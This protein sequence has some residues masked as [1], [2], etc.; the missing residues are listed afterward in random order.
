LGTTGEGVLSADTEYMWVT[1]RFNSSAFTESLH[2]NY[3][4]KIAGPSSG[5]TDTSQDITLRFGSEFPF[6]SDEESLTGFSA[7]ELIV[8]AQK[9]T[10]STRPDPT[11]WR[12]IN[13][14]S[15]ISASTVNGFV[16]PS[17]LTGNTIQITKNLYDGSSSS[18]YDLSDYID[19]PTLNQTGTTY[20]FGDDYLFN[21]NI[22][23]DIQASIYVMNY[24]CNLGQTQFLDSS[25]PTW[26][27]NA[28]YITEIGLYDSN[29]NLMIISKV[30]SPQKR[31]GVQQYP[32]KLDF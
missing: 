4:S 12:E 7:N 27:G 17:T 11:L 22:I 18:L 14:E 23:T 6:L 20:N 1:Y 2:C 10:G 5:C 30:Q 28:P 15:Q 32:I 21:G 29:K 16:V 3:Y 31:L 13:V 25:N 9:T 19:I 26:A 8:L 24:K